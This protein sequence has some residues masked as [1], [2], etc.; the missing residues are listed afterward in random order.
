MRSKTTMFQTAVME[1]R[2]GRPWGF[3]A[4]LLAFATLL[5]GGFVLLI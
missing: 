5:S 1:E 4:G 2:T 3:I